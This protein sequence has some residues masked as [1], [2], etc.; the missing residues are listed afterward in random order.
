MAVGLFCRRNGLSSEGK[1]RFC[2]LACDTT[3]VTKEKKYKEDEVVALHSCT[4][5]SVPESNGIYDLYNYQEIN[6]NFILI[7]SPSVI[8]RAQKS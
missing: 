8:I 2:S 3:T 7:G 1:F 6:L 5:R 4:H